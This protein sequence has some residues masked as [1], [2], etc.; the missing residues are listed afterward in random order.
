MVRVLGHR[1]HRV[2]LHLDGVQLREGLQLCQRRDCLHEKEE[3]QKVSPLLVR[4]SV[5][6]W[7]VLTT[8][9]ATCLSLSLSLSKHAV[10]QLLQI[11]GSFNNA[12]LSVKFT[13]FYGIL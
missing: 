8:D 1:P 4:L 9:D 10:G 5:R 3:R 6:L 7:I 11:L 13:K 12:S 2:A